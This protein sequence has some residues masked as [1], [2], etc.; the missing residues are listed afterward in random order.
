MGFSWQEYWSKLPCPPPGDLPDPGIKLE[1]S[2]SPML[3]ADS[4]S[5]EPSGKP[6]T[7]FN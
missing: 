6:L 2:V 1:S 4:L 3:Q 7:Y 5:V